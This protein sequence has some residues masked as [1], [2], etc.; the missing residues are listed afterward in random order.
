MNTE[1][2]ADASAVHV[3]VEKQTELP[4]QD[5]EEINAGVCSPVSLSL[6]Y[7]TPASRYGDNWA[8]QGSCVVLALAVLMGSCVNTCGAITITGFY[9][10][11]DIDV[12]ANVDHMNP[13]LEPTGETGCLAPYHT[14][15]YHNHTIPPTLLHTTTFKALLHCPAKT[16]P[17]TSPCVR[18]CTSDHKDGCR[19]APRAPR[20][21]GAPP[22]RRERKAPRYATPCFV[23][24]TRRIWCG[25]VR[26]GMVCAP[27]PCPYMKSSNHPLEPSQL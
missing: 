24:H 22:S 5:R 18:L 2:G 15:P 1:Q 7:Q 11:P 8:W 21:P 10:Q 12:P 14:I 9:S 23:V 20:R 3:E 26:H 27:L 6:R 17:Q 13:V 16:I 25:M 4:E 19:A